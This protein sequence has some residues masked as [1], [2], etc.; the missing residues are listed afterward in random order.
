MSKICSIC[1]KDL[2]LDNFSIN[3]GCKDNLD[4]RCKKCVT[5][6][7]KKLYST[8]KSKEYKIYEF[9]MNS[10]EW[11]VGKPKGSVLQ[12]KD[13]YRAITYDKEGLKKQKTFKTH[14]EAENFVRKKSDENGQTKNMIR[15]VDD[16]IEVKIDDNHIMKTDIKFLDLCQSR[17]IC[18]GKGGSKTASYYPKIS[19]DGK[20]HDFHKYITNFKM[21]DHINRDT[22]DNR[23]QNLRETTHKENNNNRNAN[24][25][26]DESHIMGVRYV[27]KDNAW[28]ARIKQDGK[29]YSKH[30]SVKKYGENEAKELAIKARNEFIS[31]FNSNNK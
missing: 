23:L 19:V 14:E 26:Y 29:E 21:T 5:E 24:K 1:S 18:K 3:K 7:K 25:K 28:Q 15:K 12:W 30:F 11:Q 4:P 20:P 6:Y 22:F 16:Y 13:K 2:S 31:K 8:K 9:D 10:T 17:S 27:E